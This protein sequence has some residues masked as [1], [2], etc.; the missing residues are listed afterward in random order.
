MEYAISRSKIDWREAARMAVEQ[1]LSNRK[2]AEKF[3]VNESTIRRGLASMRVTRHLLPTDPPVAERLNIEWDKPIV[4]PKNDRYAITADW[5]IPLYDAEYANKFLQDSRARGITKLIIAGDFF[6][7]D[8]LSMYEPKQELGGLEAEVAEAGMVMHTLL[9]SF[10]TV[11]FLWG[12]HDA[13]L[14][15]A[16]GFAMK[17]QEAMKLVFG[18]L[19]REELDRIRFTNLD[20]MWVGD[21]DEEGRW[22]ICHPGSYTRVPLST[23][24]TLSTKYECNVITAHSHHC[25]VGYGINAKNVV[26]E[27]GGLFDREKTGYLQRT[28]TYPTWA[29]GYAFLDEGRLYVQSPGWQVG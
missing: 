23:A 17:F 8:A 9:Q 14:H 20:H 4:V 22:Y 3:G 29:Q 28:T 25:A 11:Y 24:R 18:P 2:I 5:H 26:A 16:L 6:N 27:I 1:N 12:N 15:K 19:D 10:D 13:R 7:F 21:E